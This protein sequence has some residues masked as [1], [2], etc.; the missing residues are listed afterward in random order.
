MQSSC[1]CCSCSDTV[2]AAVRLVEERSKVRDNLQRFGWTAVWVEPHTLLPSSYHSTEAHFLLSHVDRWKDLHQE[3]FDAEY[4]IDSLSEVPS[5]TWRAAESGSPTSLEPKQSWE[6]Q[7]GGL[8][9]LSS[10]LLVHRRMDAWATLLHHVAISVAEAL[11]W[12]PNTLVCPL[13]RSDMDLLRAFSYDVV[14]HGNND[15]DSKVMF[16]SSEHTDWG[17]LTIVWQDH[18][19][20]LETCCRKHNKWNPV[21]PAPAPSSHDRLVLIVHMGDVASLAGQGPSPLH[22]V[23]SPQHERRNSLVYFLYPPRS[24]GSLELIQENM[25]F[26]DTSSLNFEDYSLLQDQSQGG[27]HDG[28][29]AK[30]RYEHI[31]SMSTL[32]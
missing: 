22:R 13:D 29:T 28:T 1:A 20:G 6:L 5:L 4:R 18:V 30:Q 16:G 17:S 14:N 25:G 3:L 2:G 31:R 10:S 32:R 24:V 7:R 15:D 12:P 9:T 26:D 19:G 21:A 8:P 23:K 11:E 27:K